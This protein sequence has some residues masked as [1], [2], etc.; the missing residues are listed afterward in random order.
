MIDSNGV[1]LI[2]DLEVKSSDSGGSDPKQYSL[3]PYFGRRLGVERKDVW[4]LK[5][6]EDDPDMVY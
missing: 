1:F 3:G 2:L 4:D 6:S 5:W